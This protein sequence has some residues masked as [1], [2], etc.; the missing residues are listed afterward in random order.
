VR[1]R[2]TRADD[3][4]ALRVEVL[5]SGWK[6]LRVRLVGHGGAS[7]AVVTLPSGDQAQVLVPDRW[8]FAGRPLA[9]GRGPVF[10]V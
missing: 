7:S 3:A 8:A 5:Q 9:V 6:P 10:S 2:A 1:F 4:I